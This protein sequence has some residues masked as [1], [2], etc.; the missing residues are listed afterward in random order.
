MKYKKIYLQLQLQNAGAKKSP[1]DPDKLTLKDK[2]IK[3]MYKLIVKKKLS[4][5]K[6]TMRVNNQKRK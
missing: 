5:R 2:V 4:K 1:L 6:V 3:R